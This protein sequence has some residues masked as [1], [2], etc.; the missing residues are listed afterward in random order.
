[1][2]ESATINRS[3]RFQ[4][5]PLSSVSALGQGA[6]FSKYLVYVRGWPPRPALILKPIERFEIGSDVFN[7]LLR[8]TLSARVNP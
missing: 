2:A 4:N 1:M 5:V 7:N 6:Q 8:P 3:S